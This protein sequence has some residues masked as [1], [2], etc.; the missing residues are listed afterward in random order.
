[1]NIF[2][3][4]TKTTPRQMDEQ[5]VR[6]AQEPDELTGRK[7]GLFNDM[8]SKRNSVRSAPNAN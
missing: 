7:D 1:M 8:Q 6:T 3:N 5:T 4:P 2:S